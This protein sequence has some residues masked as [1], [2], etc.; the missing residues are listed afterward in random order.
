MIT[1][2]IVIPPEQ[3][4]FLKLVHDKIEEFMSSPGQTIELPKGN[5][6]QR[7]LIYQ[8]VKEKFTD[9]SLQSVNK[10]GGDRVI[11]A[12]K[13]DEEERKR[14]GD[15]KDKIELSELDI[16]FGFSKVIKKMTSSGKLVVG[17]NMILDLAHTINQFVGPLPDSYQDFKS[18]SRDVFPAIL[19]TKLM[20]NTIPFKD[21]I[22]NSTLEGM[23][24]IV[25]KEPYKMP[26]CPPKHSDR[27]YHLKTA[28]YHEAGYDAF[29][30]GLCFIAMSHRLG[31]LCG[32]KDTP[33]HPTSSH[34]KPF[35]NK[36]FIMRVADIPYMNLAGE[37]VN[38][39]RSHVFHIQ[40]PHAWKRTDLDLLFSPFGR[41]FV[42]W[43]DDSSAFISLADRPDK[44]S[45]LQQLQTSSTYKITPYKKY[46][47]QKE[48]AKS[49]ESALTSSGKFAPHSLP[50]TPVSL[51]QPSCG[52]TPMMEKS[53]LSFDCSNGDAKKRPISPDLVQ[54]KRPKS[55]G[56]DKE[57][58]KQNGDQ[59]EGEKEVL[60]QNGDQKE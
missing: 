55:V 51:Q 32:P 31:S 4:E 20:A 38:P 35:L 56:E 16:A 11:V 34:I 18:M 29:V 47:E 25:T 43:I 30:T 49:A 26:D 6:F 2:R 42:S 27:G 57:V 3:E 28:K 10:T 21:E 39:E 54:V 44:E 33:V 41:I 17:H 52:I 37:E 7:R 36:L 48:Q 40:F 1:R 23:M 22:Y 50:C 45:V 46:Q 19:D 53:N 5:G 24:E 14:L 15:L 58:L 12:V 59:K 8:T 9:I 13:A 60:K